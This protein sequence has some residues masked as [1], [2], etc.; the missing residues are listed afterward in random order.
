MFQIIAEAL[1]LAAHASVPR[2]TP[3]RREAPPVRPGLA[4]PRQ[5]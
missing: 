5:G 3:T 2:S 4:W 1:S